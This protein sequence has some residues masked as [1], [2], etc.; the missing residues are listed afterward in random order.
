MTESNTTNQKNYFA[1]IVPLIGLYIAIAC[2]VSIFSN[3]LNQNNIN[4]NVLQTVNILILVLSCINIKLYSN[5]AKNKNPNASVQSVLLATIIKLFVL[6]G[7]V[8]GYLIIEKNRSVYAIFGGMFFY[9]LYTIVEKSIAM[10][11]KK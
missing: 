8:F 4:V 1:I 2:T 6:G 9:I 5:A 7:A 10:K 3:K 11:I